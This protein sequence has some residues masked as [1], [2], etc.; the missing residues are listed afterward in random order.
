MS[1]APLTDL[2]IR[3]LAP[4]AGARDEIWDAK[5]PGLG[6][7]A[8]AHGTKTFVVM[9][10]LDGRKCR[11][12]LGRYPIVTLAEARERARDILNQVSKGIDPQSRSETAPAG[13]LFTAIVDD[14]VRKYCRQHNRASTAHETERILRARFVPAWGDRPIASITTQDVRAVMTAIMEAGTPSA[15]N[16]ALAAIRKLFNWCVEEDIIGGVAVRACAPAG[17]GRFSRTG[18]HR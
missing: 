11:V 6:L 15:A 17:A 10:R 12:T 18:A 14:F 4:A 2:A 1:R 5:V 7:R 13:R 9:Y 16:H 3:G 8:S